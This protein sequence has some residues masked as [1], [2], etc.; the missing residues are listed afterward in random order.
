M[1]STFIGPSNDPHHLCLVVY[2]MR[3]G[4]IP[5]LSSHGNSKIA[6]PFLPWPSTLNRIKKECISKGPK[7]V[8]EQVSSEVGGVSEPGQLPRNE[9]QVSNQKRK[10]KSSEA[11][12]IV[13]KN[14]AADDLFVIMQQAHTQDPSHKFVRDIKTA[15]EPA[16]VLASEQ[17]HNDLVRFCICSEEFSIVTIAPL[18]VLANLM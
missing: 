14:A 3:A 1:Y 17:Q 18:L 16:I 11:V 10:G 5:T 7:A 15:P 8:V 13:G 4:F 6:R 2:R 9:L 12:T